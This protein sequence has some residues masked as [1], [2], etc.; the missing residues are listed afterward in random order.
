MPSSPTP[1]DGTPRHLR[2]CAARAAVVATA[3]VAAALLAVLP[4][5]DPAA[6]A[7]AAPAPASV[8]AEVTSV[9]FAAP[10]DPPAPLTPAAVALQTALGKVGSPYRW[11]GSG[12]SSFDCSG[13]VTFAFRAAGVELPRTSRALSQVGTPV[14][15]VDLQPGDLVF[16]YNPVRHV[17][18]YVGD[19]LLVH[20]SRAGRPVAV[21]DMSRMPFHSARRI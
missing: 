19:G 14:A 9:S 2:S 17:G 5:V 21:V 1:T 3:T 12:P 6:A 10:V 4:A 16:F 8:H 15:P 13:L 11:G 18:I 20:A 7:G